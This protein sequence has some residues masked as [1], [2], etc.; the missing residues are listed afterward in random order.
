MEETI[1]HVSIDDLILRYTENFDELKVSHDYLKNMIKEQ[2]I[3][4]SPSELSAFY[5][6][7][8]RHY[9]IGLITISGLDVL[10][11][12]SLLKKS[13]FQWEKIFLLRKGCLTIYETIIAFENKKSLIKK[14]INDYEIGMEVITK[15][16]IDIKSYKKKYNFGKIN[17][18]RNKVAGHYDESF[19]ALYDTI[20][21]INYTEVVSAL[22]ELYLILVQISEFLFHLRSTIN[23]KDR[24]KL[25]N[26][27]QTNLQLE[28]E[29]AELMKKVVE[30]KEGEKTQ[31]ENIF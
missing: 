13:T 11:L 17:R 10:C 6:I 24:E 2:S 5:D 8:L 14:I 9:L 29:L 31:I 1:N 27:E 3:S 25:L 16:E 7:E 19:D 28:L 23:Q 30:I 21:E 22:N 4:H 20:V 18:I 15:V 12:L 26:M